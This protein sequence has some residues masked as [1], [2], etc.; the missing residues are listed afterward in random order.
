MLKMICSGGGCR[1]EGGLA[2]QS[3]CLLVNNL[4]STP[5]MEQ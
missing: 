2:G 3:V 1:W 4:G 5:V